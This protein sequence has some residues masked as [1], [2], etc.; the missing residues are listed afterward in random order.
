MSK[1]DWQLKNL[2]VRFQVEEITQDEYRAELERLRRQRKVYA[3]QAE[4]EPDPRELAS[5]TGLWRSGDPG[6][7]WEVLTS[8]FEK[9]HVTNR[10]ITS[11][12]PRADRAARVQQLVSIAVQ[13]MN[14]E[15]DID[16]GEGQA[17]TSIDLAHSEGISGAGGISH[18]ANPGPEVRLA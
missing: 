1:I 17:V 7:Q 15:A 10:R 5:L 3:S 6:R 11:Y 16:W 14:P 4:S 8:L 2:G 13:T 12:T 9:L 18:A